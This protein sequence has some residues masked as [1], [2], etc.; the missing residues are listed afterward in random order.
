ME[1]LI[2][3]LLRYSVECARLP[4]NATTK[5]LFQSTHLSIFKPETVSRERHVW[6]K[7]DYPFAVCILL[8]VLLSQ[9]SILY[10]G[11]L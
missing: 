7:Q 1:G 8:V 9:I 3:G 5:Q 2:F 11:R 4:F 6:F 10:L